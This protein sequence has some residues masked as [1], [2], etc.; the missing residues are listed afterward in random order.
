M[1]RAAA[2]I[3]LGLAASIAG[4]QPY[5]ISWSTVDGG[6]TSSASGGAFELAG[7]AGQP[8]AGG[9]FAGSPF[10]LHGGFW[11]IAAGSGVGPQ[12]DLSITK[13]DG[14]STAVPGTTVTYTI[15]ASNAGP[16]SVAS[17]TVIDAPPASVVGVTWTCTASAGSSCPAS[18]A[19]AINAAVSLQVGGSATFQLAGTIDPAATGTLANTASVTPPSGVTDP[20]LANNSATDTDPLDP[21]ADLVL[22]VSDVPDP[23]APGAPLVYTLGITNVGPSRSPGMTLTSI[24]DPAL[25]DFVASTPGAPNCT[26]A[27]NALTCDLGAVDPGGSA[28]VTLEVRVKPAAS[29]TIR[30]DA[31]VAGDVA[32]PVSANNAAQAL[33]AVQA[34]PPVTELAHGTRLERALTAAVG[35]AGD[36]FRLRQDAYSS[37]EVAVDAASGDLGVGDGPALERLDAGGAI[38]QGSQP[39]GTGPARSLRFANATSAAIDDQIVRVRTLNATQP[40]GPED[41]YRLRAWD[42]TMVVPRFNNS[43]SQLTVVLLQNPTAAPVAATLFFWSPAGTLLATYVPAGPL[44]PKG[45]L[46][47]S[48][49]G[50]PGLAGTSGSITVVHDAPYGAIAG[51][52]VAL[53][54]STGFSFDSPM[55]PRPR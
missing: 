18:G 30:N 48:T 5:E 11:A 4:A 38:L 1:M 28:V 55:L 20:A 40:A 9:P 17:A 39:V 47:L 44:P 8:D 34:P 27:L 23:V 10:V 3:I 45:L 42:T 14:Q 16:A 24:P 52:T 6:G 37:Y 36:R 33:T 43:G 26:Y 21:R 2:T 32:D 53:E 19:G 22:A 25:V 46:V 35:A 29:A 13:T 7:T 15:L 49:A 54:P 41:T 12:A 51:K 50:V 31:N